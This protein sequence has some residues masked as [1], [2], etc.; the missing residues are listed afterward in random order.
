[1][2]RNVK[3]NMNTNFNNSSFSIAPYLFLIFLFCLMVS[4]AVMIIYLERKRKEVIIKQI[5]S[6]NE[7]MIDIQKQLSD[8]RSNIYAGGASY[9]LTEEDI[10]TEILN[11]D[12]L[13]AV[14]PENNSCNGEFYE[15][16]DGCCR[17]KS[18]A[19]E[20]AKEQHREM[21]KSMMVEVGVTMMAEIII[22]SVLPRI[23]NQILKGLS[24][25]A[26]AKVIGK[27]A[28]M[29][30]VKLS[31]KLAAMTARILV[32]LGSG[33][34]G[35]V[36][37]LFDMISIGM[38][39]ADTNNYNSFLENKMNVETRDV[40]VY[41]YYEAIKE[42]GGDFPVLFPYSLLFPDESTK[43]MDE[44]NLKMM[45]DYILEFTEIE[46]GT[47]YL[48]D[49][50]TGVA[51]SETEGTDMPEETP[52]EMEKGLDVMGRFF[53]R[54]RDKHHVKLDKYTF[55]LL[56]NEIPQS[57][58]DD[59]I[60]IESM[61]T[62]AS[63][64]IGISEQ[65]AIKWNQE[66]REDWFQYLD[67]FFPPNI[68]EPDWVPPMMAVYTDKYLAP[69]LINPGTENQPNLIYKTLSKPVTLAYPFGPL[70]TNC[71]KERTSARYKEPI[72]PVDFGVKFDG[73]KG[74]CEFTRN[75][76]T[77]YGID[78]KRKTWKD[79]TE[80]T[81]CEVSPGQEVAEAIFGTTVTRKAKQYW[82]DPGS[83]PTDLEDTFNQRKE[84]H[85][86]A[87]AV[88]LTIFDPFGFKEGLVSNFAEQMAGRDKHCVTG[89]TCKYFT[90]DHKGGNFMSWSARDSEGAVYSGG[91]GFQRQVK[92]G[93]DHTFYVPEG[94]YFR[95]KCD[96]GEGKNF[97]YDEIPDNGTKRFTCW[98]GKVN[99]PYN[100][101]DT[102]EQGAEAAVDAA[103]TVVEGVEKGANIIAEGVEKGANEVGDFFTG[104]FSDLR[105]KSNIKRINVQ[106]PINGINVYI[107][108]WNETAMSTYGLRGQDIGFITDEI[109]DKYVS[110][111]GLGFEF[112]RQGTPIY[113]ALKKFKSQY[114]L[115]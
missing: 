68:P 70:V 98:N 45:T 106:S 60:F 56:Q 83:I 59:I 58:K 54:V 21:V 53:D 82:N 61:S 111:D 28:K 77:R 97:P 94:G 20:L 62:R 95:V 72:N 67:P 55:D 86:E 92:D 64:G 38:D 110:K 46:G 26:L 52:E 100:P 99:K 11:P 104:V 43:V 22:T 87:A 93:E 29:A 16:K 105:L 23:G 88:A 40:L 25:K 39:I 8:H 112:I 18:N 76:C 6:T 74:I 37:L 81:D 91:M 103:Q 47:E 27:A 33:P 32:K 79:G 42:D 69:N 4:V 48:V 107:W 113:D 19:D 41:K 7:R 17:L 66:K 30:V 9:G 12:I 49:L 2:F 34:V 36:L 15:L 1:M 44:V 51:T 31:V 5:K 3:T 50:F 73:V 57:R 13:C 102:V 109:D 108:D 65:A 114:N 78:F 89:D 24:S 14:Y 101:L 71:E 10:N 63:T 35:W 85:G 75:Y 115:K 84:Q 96:P 80:Y 90:A